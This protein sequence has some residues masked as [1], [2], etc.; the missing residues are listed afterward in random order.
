[1]QGVVRKL[2]DDIAARYTERAGGY[3]R[4]TKIG[5]TPAG[6]EEAVIEFV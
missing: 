1:M 4:I 2:F 5:R 3:T 6:R